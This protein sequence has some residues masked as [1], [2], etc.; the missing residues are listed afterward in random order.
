MRGKK[1]KA[2]RRALS[3]AGMKPSAGAV[4]RLKEGGADTSDLH[5]KA[6]RAQTEAT[7]AAVRTAK[8]AARGRTFGGRAVERASANSVGLEGKMRRVARKVVVAKKKQA[9]AVAAE[10][11]A[12]RKLAAGEGEG[13][14]PVVES[15]VPESASC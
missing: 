10:A 3:A 15:D 7:A 6:L 2:L 8:A 12:R 4:R 9:Y 5:A 13:P 14:W 1:A 11:E